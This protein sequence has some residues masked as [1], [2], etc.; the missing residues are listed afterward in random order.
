MQRLVFTK[1]GLVPGMGRSDAN[2]P[3][4]LVEYAV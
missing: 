3:S 4:E 2:M 1:V